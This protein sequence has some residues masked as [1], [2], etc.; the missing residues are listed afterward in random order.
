MSEVRLGS[1]EAYLALPAKRSRRG[2]L[3]LHELFGVTADIRRI[4]DELAGAG[5]VALAPA[6][7]RRG[8]LARTLRSASRHQLLDGWRRY[9]RE[10]HQVE[11]DAV[12]GFCLGGG[13]ALI[14]AASGPEQPLAVVAPNYGFVPRDLERLCPVVA[15]YGAAD[16]RLVPQAERLDRELDRLAIDHD[17][18]VYPGAGHSF[19]NHHQG[20]L[21]DFVARVSPMPIGFHEAAAR[22]AWKRIYAF[23]DQQ[24]ES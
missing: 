21:A 11:R 10:E 13:L 5:Y 1:C 20:R 19:M 8:C 15:S 4:S 22:D 6:L 18:K 24:M 16:R 3:V 23:L 17:V 2:V 14:Y 7:L 9:L 12:I